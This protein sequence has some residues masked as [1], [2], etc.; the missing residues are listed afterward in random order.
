[1]T[2]RVLSERQ[3]EAIETALREVKA[4]CEMEILDDPA[5]S[6]PESAIGHMCPLILRA[7]DALMGV[8]P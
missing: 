4:H 1:M 6:H 2:V 3:A 8:E 5:L 7:L